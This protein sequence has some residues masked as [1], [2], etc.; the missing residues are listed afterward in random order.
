MGDEG[1]FSLQH[2]LPADELSVAKLWIEA[3]TI[4]GGSS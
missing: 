3:A 1:F 4:E 2:G